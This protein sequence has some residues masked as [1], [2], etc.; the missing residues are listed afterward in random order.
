M[1]AKILVS[2]D[3]LVILTYGGKIK[4]GQKLRG[5]ARRRV[6]LAARA[7]VAQDP[8]RYTLQS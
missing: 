4:R 5:R 8:G 7:K 1:R 6:L 3:P 2:R